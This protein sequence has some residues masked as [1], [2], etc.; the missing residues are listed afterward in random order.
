MIRMRSPEETFP[1]SLIVFLTLQIGRAHAELQSRFDLVCRLLLEKKK[2]GSSNEIS[3]RSS[4]CLLERQCER[5][6]EIFEA[7][8]EDSSE[9]VLVELVYVKMSQVSV[10]VLLGKQ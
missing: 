5:V 9:A 10:G 4:L 7:M 8:D 2:L 1:S 6:A 3:M